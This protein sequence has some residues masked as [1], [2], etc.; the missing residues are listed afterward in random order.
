[1]LS[2]ILLRN[3]CRLY[4]KIRQ[5]SRGPRKRYAETGSQSR[6]LCTHG[7]RRS[8]EPAPLQ[9]LF[10]NLLRGCLYSEPCSATGT[11]SGTLSCR[12]S[13]P[14]LPSYEVLVVDNAPSDAHSREAALRWGVRYLTEPVQGVTR[15]RNR[16][17]HACKTEIVAYLDDD[18]VADPDWLK[19][20][21][22][23]FCG[24]SGSSGDRGYSSN[25]S[26]ACGNR[27][28]ETQD[29][30]GQVWT[31]E[32]PTNATQPKLMVRLNISNGFKVYP[33]TILKRWRS[34][35]RS[36][37]WCAHP[38]V[39][40]PSRHPVSADAVCVQLQNAAAPAHRMHRIG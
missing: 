40:P 6:S 13:L 33:H 23:G 18:A 4:S 32:L 31:H 19:V 27:R 2:C 22:R 26:A 21:T 9:R 15:A 5:N 1:M 12:I 35:R 36:Q 30:K 10:V 3:Y 24:S 34:T 11:L 28:E 29:A 7:I 17:A 14:E 16:G 8:L 39:P 37:G 38:E 20:L 25:Q